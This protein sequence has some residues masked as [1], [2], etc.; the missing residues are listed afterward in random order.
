M[1]YWRGIDRGKGPSSPET[2]TGLGVIGHVRVLDP[3]HSGENYLTRE[4]GFRIARKH[5]AKLRRIAVVM[6][7]LLAALMTV[8]GFA[9]GGPMAV[10]PAILA[11]V[12][13]S[14]GIV[15]ERWLFFA[16]AKHVVILYYGGDRA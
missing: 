2:A 8:I 5:A 13:G 3:P 4:L 14:L 10:V 1:A 7:F 16:E 12:C 11:A 15:L 6:G 9:S